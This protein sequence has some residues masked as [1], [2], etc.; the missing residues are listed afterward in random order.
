MSTL[1]LQGIILRYAN[2]RDN[3]R[4][5]T[6]LTRERGKL[7]AAARG[8]RKPASRLFSCS[9]MFIFGEFVL[10]EG[11][12]R[13]TVDNCEV[14]ERFYPLREDLHR[15]AAGAYM[16][17]VADACLAA[18]QRNEAVFELLYYGLSY[19]A[20]GS[21]H[22]TDVALC[23]LA[24]CLQALGYSPQLTSCARCGRDLR[25]LLRLGFDPGAGGAVC[26]GCMGPDTMDISPL[27]LEA[28]RRMLLLSNKE[29]NRVVLPEQVRRELKTALNGYAEYLLERPL[30]AAKQ[31]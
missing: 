12:S 18:E 22:P 16:T 4:I 20:Y 27:S 28:V 9:E 2:Y 11:R 15:F 1:T 6:I 30:R 13:M 25:A 8:C 14:R 10:Y 5:L 17:S 19:A 24:R 23:F 31:L 7:S 21:Q 3:D 26:Q 29:M